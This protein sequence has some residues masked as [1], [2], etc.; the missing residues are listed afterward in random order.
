MIA[1]DILSVIIILI[2]I[3]FY[4]PLITTIFVYNRWELKSKPRTKRIL[5][6]SITFSSTFIILL[7]LHLVFRRL[8]EIW[9]FVYGI[10]MTVLFIGDKLSKRKIEF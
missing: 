3:L 8:F 5:I 2:F 10:L 9:L 4:N 6:S 7:L 1:P